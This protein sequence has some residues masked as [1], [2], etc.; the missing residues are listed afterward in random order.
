MAYFYFKKTRIMNPF[1]FLFAI[2]IVSLLGLGCG[3]TFNS[4][5]ELYGSQCDTTNVTYSVVQP[6][7]QAN[8]VSCHNAEYNNRGIILDTYEDAVAAA[9]TGRLIKAVNHLPGA[10]PMPYGGNKLPVCEV[11]KITIWIEMGTPE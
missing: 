2:A 8:C 9:Q 5:E 11:R 7:F 4:E 6:I 1:P 3:C 10:T